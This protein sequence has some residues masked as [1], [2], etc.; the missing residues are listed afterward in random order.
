LPPNDKIQLPEVII[1]YSNNTEIKF[2]YDERNRILKK[3]YYSRENGSLAAT[4]TYTYNGDDLI[5]YVYQSYTGSHNNSFNYSI[6]ENKITLELY[7]LYSDGIH[8][9]QRSLIHLNIDGY[10]T[11]KECFTYCYFSKNFEFL[12]AVFTFHF[13]NGNLT[14]SVIQDYQQIDFLSC[15]GVMESA[16]YGNEF[17][18]DNNKTPFYYCKMSKWYGISVHYG[19]NNKNN[20]IEM[21]TPNTHEY[22]E[23]EYDSAGFQIRRTHNG[24]VDME[25]KYMLK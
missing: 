1:D 15:T 10:P 6:N 18:F 25:I 8:L 5:K 19:F 16:T 11:H 13:E 4:A 14:K 2:E 20:V 24:K 9:S 21:L 23:Y 12:D 17:K 7:S 3:L 22:Y